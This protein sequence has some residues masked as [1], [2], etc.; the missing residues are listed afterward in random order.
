M[1]IEVSAEL[2]DRAYAPIFPKYYGKSLITKKGTYHLVI[3][4]TNQ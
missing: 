1:I 4:Y 2:Q 3:A